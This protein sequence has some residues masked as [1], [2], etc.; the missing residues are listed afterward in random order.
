ML[1]GAIVRELAATNGGPGLTA[2]ELSQRLGAPCAV[3]RQALSVLVFVEGRVTVEHGRS[4]GGRYKLG[5][6]ARLLLVE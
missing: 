2:V 4:G 5:D 1:A 6:P 3:V